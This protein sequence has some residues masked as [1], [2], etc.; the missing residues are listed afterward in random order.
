MSARTTWSPTPARPP[1]SNRLGG[2]LATAALAVALAGPVPLQA[3]GQPTY[4][5]RGGEIHTLVG[6]EVIRNGSVLIQNGRIA[7]VGASVQAPAGATEVDVSGLRVYPGYFDSYTRLG[8]TE[9]GSVDVTQDYDELGDWNPQLVAATA[10]HPASELIPVARTNGIT[11]AVSAP[12]GGGRGG[13]YGI[14][15]QATLLNLSGWTE[16]EMEAAHSVGM[17]LNWPVIRGGGRGF[18]FGRQEEGTQAF[19]RAMDEYEDHLAEFRDWF[20]AAKHQVQVMR[21]N[22]ERARRD[23]SL[24]ALGKVL[25]GEI[26]MIISVNEARDIRNA[27][28]FAE[29]EGLDYIIAGG[30][31]AHEVAD[32]LAEH[33]TRVI[34]AAPQATPSGPDASYDEAYATAGKLY[35][36]GVE[37]AIATFNDSDVRTLPYEAGTAAAFGLPKDA[38]LRAITIEPARILGVDDDYGTIE[39]GKVANLVVV[40]G[41]PLEI[42]T[43]VQHVFIDGEEISLVDKHRAL[44]DKYRARPE[45]G[46][47]G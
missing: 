35:A 2:A 10:V 28:E 46:G 31:M 11:H 45:S 34:L 47:G 1:A 43:I 37:F 36:A 41:E 33:H 24:E 25:D 9:I 13:G 21:A 44:Y 40:D 30:R 19:R 16:E 3:Q 20:E 22:P 42:R 7:A 8:L 14:P 39:E 4:V 18:R 26:P 23:I 15:G 17:I 27:V 32:F 5:L 29:D 12:G 6:D 38:A